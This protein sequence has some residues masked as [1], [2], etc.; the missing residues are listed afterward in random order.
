[1]SWLLGKPTRHRGR[2][3]CLSQRNRAVLTVPE[4]GSDAATTRD[5]TFPQCEDA[6]PLAPGTCRLWHRQWHMDHKYSSTPVRRV[7]VSPEGAGAR[8]PELGAGTTRRTVP[9]RAVAFGSCS[10]PASRT[11][12]GG[13]CV[14]VRVPPII[15]WHLLDEDAVQDAE[16]VDGGTRSNDHLKTSVGLER[17]QSLISTLSC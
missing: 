2:P 15:K 10:S 3:A 5:L 11:A 6:E 4:R 13:V 9:R 7:H 1:M 8:G 12:L 16:V 17:R 14:S